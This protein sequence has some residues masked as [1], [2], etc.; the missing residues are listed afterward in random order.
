MRFGGKVIESR[1][2]NFLSLMY[3][4]KVNSIQQ[5]NISAT[6]LFIRLKYKDLAQ[7]TSAQK[8]IVSKIQNNDKVIVKG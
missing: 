7:F 8:S 6:N 4:L 3:T 1:D 5:N 2:G